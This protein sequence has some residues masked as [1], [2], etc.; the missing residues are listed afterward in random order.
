MDTRNDRPAE[1]LIP[2]EQDTITFYGHELVAVRLE[3][4]RIA[5]VLRWLFESL[6][7]ERRGQMQRI[8]RKTALRDVLIE[9][10]VDTEGGP[11]T[12]PALTLDVLP[13]YLFT[14]DEGRV[15]PE[16]RD[17]VIVFQ[18]ECVKVL[19]EHFARKHQA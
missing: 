6:S 9:V 7:L 19:A 16:A 14:I 15:R 4:G 18:R 5:A 3:D 1:A 11:Q 13:G 2:I 12:M 8:E 17:D 10:R